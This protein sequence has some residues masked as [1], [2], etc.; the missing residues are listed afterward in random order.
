MEVFTKVPLPDPI[1]QCG[2]LYWWFS[3]VINYERAL[4]GKPPIEIDPVEDRRLYCTATARALGRHF[5]Y[6]P[7]STPFRCLASSWHWCRRMIGHGTQHSA[8][9]RG[10]R[11][12]K[13][14]KERC[15]WDASLK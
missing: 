10:D 2:R 11:G 4:E 1:K 14:R 5:Q 7:L 9:G 15:V 6:D 3:Q 8:R 12:P 13:G